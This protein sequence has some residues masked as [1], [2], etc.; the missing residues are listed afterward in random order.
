MTQSDVSELGSYQT[1][2]SEPVVKH[3]AS[4]GKRR[5]RLHRH[6]GSADASAALRLNR[7]GWS[8]WSAAN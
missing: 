8:S 2:A 1:T 7:I 4:P 3:R 6:A 5:F